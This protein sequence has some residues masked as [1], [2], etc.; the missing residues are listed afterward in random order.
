MHQRH[1]LRPFLQNLN[2]QVWRQMHTVPFFSQF[3]KGTKTCSNHHWPLCNQTEGVLSRRAPFLNILHYKAEDWWTETE[4]GQTHTEGQK[5]DEKSF[6][7]FVTLLP[8]PCDVRF[9]P[10]KH[11]IKLQE[12]LW[13]WQ[14]I[15]ETRPYHVHQGVSGVFTFRYLTRPRPQVPWVA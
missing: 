6:I 2:I 13:L 14:N 15:E 7:P 10:L 5:E 3:L 8:I 1:M 4:T 9:K 12:I 11:D